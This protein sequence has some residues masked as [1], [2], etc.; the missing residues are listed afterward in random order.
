MTDQIVPRVVVSV[1]VMKDGKTLLNFRKGSFA[2][3]KFGVPGGKLDAMETFQACAERECMEE[4]GI[5]VEL[6]HGRFNMRDRSRKEQLVRDSAG[7]DEA[8]RQPI[9][10][11]ATQAV[12]VSLDRKSTRLNSSH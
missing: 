7:R 2:A 12:E 11:V 5:K 6:L 10:L 8:K 4:A 1:I 3:D 9:V